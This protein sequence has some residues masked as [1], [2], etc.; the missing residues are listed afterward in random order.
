MLRKPATNASLI[1]CRPRGSGVS[2][3]AS[4]DRCASISACAGD[5]RRRLSRRR[6]RAVSKT[7]LSIAPKTATE[8]R[9]AMRCRS[10][11]ASVGGEPYQPRHDLAGRAP[12]ER[13]D[14]Q[15]TSDAVPLNDA[16]LN[17]RD[18][19]EWHRPIERDGSNRDFWPRDD[20]ANFLGCPFGLKKICAQQRDEE[21]TALQLFDDAL[22]PLV[23]DLQ[24]VMGKK[25]LDAHLSQHG[26]GFSTVLAIR[27][28]IRNESPRLRHQLRTLSWPLARAALR[29]DLKT[30]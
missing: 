14:E 10:V 17:V 5:G 9:A 18:E 12:G 20:E 2:M 15:F 27:V 7:V 6:P 4:L 28:R 8:R 11:V 1:A 30:W 26:L 21:I 22:A 19:T 24:I 23:G 16:G 29:P 13:L 3:S 25:C